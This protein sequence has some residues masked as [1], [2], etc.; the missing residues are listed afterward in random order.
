ML[1][2]ELCTV[3]GLANLVMYAEL[4]RLNHAGPQQ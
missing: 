2:L 1:G 3:L 4:W